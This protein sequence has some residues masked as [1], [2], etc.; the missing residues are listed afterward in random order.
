MSITTPI[1][2]NSPKSTVLS[3]TKAS[4]QAKD[5]F[6]EIDE[7]VAATDTPE[8]RERLSAEVKQAKS[9]IQTK[10]K[11][12]EKGFVIF[13]ID[14]TTLDNR[15]FYRDPDRIYYKH[16]SKGF[17]EAWDQWILS[18][19][20][21][22]IEPTKKLIGWL[23]A[24]GIPYCFV[25]GRIEEQKAVTLQNLKQAGL[26]GDSYQGIYCKSNDWRN[27]TT[28]AHKQ[29]V[30]P[31][32]EKELGLKALASIGDAPTDMMLPEKERNFKL[33][34]SEFYPPRH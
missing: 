33:S 18:G 13:D 11:A 28:A 2:P 1:L 24:E 16:P 7:R 30:V 29:T 26:I 23:N 8:F 32:I 4:T 25:T 17:Y 3:P 27:T 34:S 21:P 31:K 22:A 15:T 14:E 10:V 6:A 9:F 19:Q 5:Q 12:G 20:A